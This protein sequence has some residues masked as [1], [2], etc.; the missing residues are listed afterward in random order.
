MELLCQLTGF[1]KR[2]NLILC[3]KKKNKKKL[4]LKLN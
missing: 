1:C 4:A 3:N 2:V